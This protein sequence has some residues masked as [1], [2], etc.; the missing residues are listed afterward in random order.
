[1]QENQE[2]MYDEDE[3]ENEGRRPSFSNAAIQR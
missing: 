2:V 1:M 3:E